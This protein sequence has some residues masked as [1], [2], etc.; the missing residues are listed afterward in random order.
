M[1]KSFSISKDDFFENSS[2]F[3]FNQR[4]KNFVFVP[5]RVSS[6]G[7]VEP[8]RLFIHEDFFNALALELPLEKYRNL[9]Y[10]NVVD[11][12]DYLGFD[13]ALALDICHI[14]IGVYVQ[15]EDIVTKYPEGYGNVLVEAYKTLSAFQETKNPVVQFAKTDPAAIVPSKSRASDAGLDLTIIKVVKSSGN[16][17]LFDTCIAAK[18]S[19]GWYLD[20][21]PRSSISSTGYILANSVGIIDQTYTGS[22]KIGLLKIDSSKPDLELP[23]R[24]AQAILR[25]CINPMIRVVDN[26]D[27]T[28]RGA[29]GFGSTGK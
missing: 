28:E 24:I 22:I 27:Q 17:T 19:F 10:K 29:G 21:V 8:S 9:G 7:P 2:R 20:V 26:L 25:P 4:C 3:T 5:P 14:L 15:S 16:Y 13:N 6:S 12:D 11:H 1:D 23:C 18:P